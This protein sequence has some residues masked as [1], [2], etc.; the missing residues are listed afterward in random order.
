M[1][2]KLKGLENYFLGPFLAVKK[3]EVLIQTTKT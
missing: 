3:I 1:E 2:T